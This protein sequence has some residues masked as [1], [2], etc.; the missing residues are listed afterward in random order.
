MRG[1]VSKLCHSFLDKNLSQPKELTAIIMRFCDVNLKSICLISL[2]LSLHHTYLA[3]Q[4]NYFAFVTNKA[5][6]FRKWKTNCYW[7]LLQQFFGEWVASAPP[8]AQWTIKSGKKH[9]PEGNMLLIHFFWFATFFFFFF[10]I[11]WTWRKSVQTVSQSNV[12]WRYHPAVYCIVF[13]INIF[14]L[15]M[16]RKHLS[17]TLVFDRPR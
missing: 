1:K 14:F 17:A 2:T 7:S 8:T 15:C 11:L 10:G 3:F 12:T 4:G 5:I 16:I 13:Y 9:N 6:A